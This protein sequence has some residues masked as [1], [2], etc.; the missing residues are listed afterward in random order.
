MVETPDA[1]CGN[2]KN[3]KN[4]EETFENNDAQSNTDARSGKTK[5]TTFSRKLLETL[6]HKVETRKKKILEETLENTDAQSAHVKTFYP[7]VTY[8]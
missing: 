2:S 5:K 7:Y 6:M 4:L 8:P 3:Q 1:Q